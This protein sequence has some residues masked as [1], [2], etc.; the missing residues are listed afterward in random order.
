MNLYAQVSP[1][2]NLGKISTLEP[3]VVVP[4]T[5]ANSVSI[6]SCAL[7]IVYDPAV[8]LPKK[9]T[10]GAGI[11]GVVN[12]NLAT[13]G[14]IRIGWYASSGNV[15]LN[16]GAVIF[17]IAFSK[18]NGGK[19]DLGFDDEENGKACKFTTV[20]DGI[21]Q[22][23][24]DSPF[25]SY[26]VPGELTF[27]DESPVTIA[28]NLTASVNE[29]ISIP[30][31]VRGFKNV[32][33]VSLTLNYDPAVLSFN[34]AS[35]TTGGFPNLTFNGATPGT[36]FIGGSS[37]NPDGVSL[38]DDFVLFT[39]NCKYLGGSSALSWNNDYSTSCE[40]GGS[41]PD[42]NIL[43][44]E[45]HSSFY[46]NGLIES[47][48]LP[49]SP[50]IV[51]GIVEN[52]LNCGANGIIPLSFTNVPDGS[53]TIYYE[54]GSFTDVSI[55]DGSATISTPAGNYNNLQI[56]VNEI[57][58]ALGVHV[59]LTDPAPPDQPVI[60]ADGPTSFC[61]GG[62]VVLT[63]G[64]AVS[65]E[66]ST[67]ETTQSIT[68]SAAGTYYVTVTNAEGCSA[69]SETVEV[70]VESRPE[71]PSK[72]NCWD[73]FV[74]NNTTC[75]WENVGE[76]PVEPTPVNCW[77]E[78]SFNTNTCE[79]ENIRTQPEEP[80]LECYQTATWNETTCSWDVT[81]TQPEAPATAC[82]ETATWNETTC[83]WDVTGTQPVVPTAE[84]CWDEFVFNN[85]TCQ[86][87][88]VGE[89]PVE[90]TP[91]NC[92]DEFSFN[93]NTCEWENIGTQPEEPAVECYQTATW[94]ET[95]CS[96]DVT[97][98]QP[99]APSTTCWE[100]VSWN[101]TTCSWDVTGTQPVVPTAENCWDEFVFSNTTCQWENVGE[102]P[103]EPNPVNCWDE[104]SFNT[105]TCEWENI[106][107]QPEEPALECYQTATWNE[108]TCSWDVT[109]TQPKA[110]STTCWETATWNETTCSWDVTGTQPVV[111]SAENCWDEFVFNN[112]TCHWENVGT[113]P[114]EPAKVDDWDEFIFDPDSCVWKNIGIATNAEIIN[115]TAEIDLTFYPNPFSEKATIRYMLPEN[116]QVSINATGILGNRFTLVSNRQ[117]LAGEY[118]LNVEGD[119]LVAG[120]YQI[121][122]RFSNLN[123]Y[124]IIRTVRI[125]KR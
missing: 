21:S 28:P 111:P 49:L 42:Y 64:E 110:P 14:E 113:K 34:S 45:P 30:I 91:A 76:E 24:D 59:V 68:V 22:T 86:W 16:S 63:S 102:E 23:L 75:Q 74:F 48:S 117:K 55:S 83:S 124:E 99:E 118:F 114:V 2:T 120:V 15:T 89:E 60:S 82:W 9:V 1:I 10:T 72:E 33:V 88:N 92:W 119:I 37:T 121:T 25:S 19:T 87:E 116:G 112:T 125:I 58:S 65:Y 26:Y 32:G 73:E 4:V 13:P 62:S 90:P 3:E 8:A 7:K 67:G 84:N 77:D 106:G 17:N 5:V 38:A 104:F 80:A 94:N 78:F 50:T 31:T 97:G 81:G 98:T 51:A 108:T 54:G 71:E 44:D 105:N 29:N 103:V 53:Y 69:T 6:S 61:E 101:E 79:W 93:T 95:T 107:T 43:N 18:V 36:I 27:N 56:T 20:V 115:H 47:V 96:W 85:T 123:G 46:Q 109:G 35:N 40:Y 66:W 39:I 52:P 12:F 70:T 41:F 122:L 11:G 57:T 100:M